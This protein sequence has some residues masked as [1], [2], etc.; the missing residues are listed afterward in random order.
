MGQY[1]N[2]VAVVLG[3]GAG[4]RLFPLTHERSK[5]AVPL[6]GTY[7]LIDVPVSNCI[8]SDITQIFV[9][10][11]YNSASLNRHI[12]RTYRFSSFTTGFVE[13]LAAEQTKDNPEWFQ[14]TADAVRQML[15]HL[16]DWKVD[17]LLILSGDHL[18]RM[19][20]RKFLDRHFSTGADLTVSVVPC[21]PDE[22]E[23]FGLLKT[24]ASG[25][26][27]EFKEKPKGD[28]LE[29]MRVDTTNFGLDSEEAAKRPYL[30]SMGIY[31]FNYNKLVDLLKT[32]RTW[33]DFGREII[34]AAINNF[35]VQAYLFDGYW[36]DIGTI[37]AFYEANLDLAAPLPKFNFFDTEAPIYTRSRYL[38]P[39]KLH[40]CDIDNSMVS[41]GCIL[42]GVTARRSII[43]LRCRIDHGTTIEESIIMGSDFLESI[44]EMCEMIAQGKPAIG[45]GKDTVIKRAIIDKN[46]R[47]GNNVRLV[48]KDGI[49]HFDHESKWYYIRDGIIIVPKNAIIPD[50]TEI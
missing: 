17:T 13:V 34:P 38:P 33:V 35:N 11:Q 36:E 31:V 28:D 50:G 39:S 30:A 9:L 12:S 8:N 47:I 49:D 25:A 19:D 45:I 41:E 6:G 37:K 2:V 7:R 16:R 44:E 18:Y 32:D 14:G 20:Y 15:P 43:G 46:V 4:S 29:Q 22:A 24:D 10:T 48:N 40:D 42:N 1:D 21:R 3:G 27:H 5:P 23:E 26:I